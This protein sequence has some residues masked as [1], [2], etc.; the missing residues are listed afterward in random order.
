MER[1]LEA[2]DQMTFQT[3]LLGQRD[4]LKRELDKLGAVTTEDAL[5]CLAPDFPAL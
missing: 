5:A 2:R 1:L 3:D 4:A